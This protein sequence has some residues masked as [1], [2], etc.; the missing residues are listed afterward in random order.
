MP[1]KGPPTHTLHDVLRCRT[2]SRDKSH[3]NMHKPLKDFGVGLLLIT[4]IINYNPFY[5]MHYIIIS[6]PDFIS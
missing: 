3:M 2:A 4:T 5:H 1:T 6:K